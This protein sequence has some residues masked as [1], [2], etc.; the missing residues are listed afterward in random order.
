MERA[1]KGQLAVA[2]M[3]AQAVGRLDDVQVRSPANMA[4]TPPALH[5]W[6]ESG[7]ARASTGEKIRIRRE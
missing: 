3:V 1:R 4:T 6:G 2:V 5:A 7:A